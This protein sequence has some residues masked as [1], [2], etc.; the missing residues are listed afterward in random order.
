[1]LLFFNCVLAV[2]LVYVMEGACVR[3][4]SQNNDRSYTALN[5]SLGPRES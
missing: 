3:V 5:L 2:M 1:M 4:R